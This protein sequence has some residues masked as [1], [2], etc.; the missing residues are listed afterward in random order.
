MVRQGKTQKQTLILREKISIENHPSP[1][2]DRFITK[3]G[4]FYEEY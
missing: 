2:G 4:L 3:G 1:E